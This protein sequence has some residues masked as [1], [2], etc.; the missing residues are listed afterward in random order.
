MFLQDPD[1]LSSQSVPQS[2]SLAPASPLNSVEEVYQD[3]APVEASPTS[4]LPTSTE[5][6]VLPGSSS[7]SRIRLPSIGR[8]SLEVTDLGDGSVRTCLADL[9]QYQQL[10]VDC[11]E[12]LEGQARVLASLLAALEMLQFSASRSVPSAVE[13]SDSGVQTEQIP[14]SPAL[15]TIFDGYTKVGDEVRVSARDFQRC[16]MAV[17]AFQSHIDQ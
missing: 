7:F 16:Q 5:V 6:A 9:L 3:I 11:R 13:T 12:T 8:Y 2:P 17:E 10:L 4:P 15:S 1:L 14:V